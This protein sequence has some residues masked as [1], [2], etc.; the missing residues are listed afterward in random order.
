M[1]SDLKP[2]LIFYRWSSVVRQTIDFPSGQREERDQGNILHTSVT[3]MTFWQFYTCAVYHSSWAAYGR[4]DCLSYSTWLLSTKNHGRR[5]ATW[6]RGTQQR[7]GQGGGWSGLAPW[8]R[9]RDSS[10]TDGYQR[11]TIQVTDPDREELESD[12]FLTGCAHGLLLLHSQN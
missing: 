9:P 2:T 11:L 4:K 6:R 12:F 5:T 3:P 1:N 10:C 7:P 8:R